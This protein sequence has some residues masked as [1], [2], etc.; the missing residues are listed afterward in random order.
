MPISFGSSGNSVANVSSVRQ[1]RAVAFVIADTVITKDVHTVAASGLSN[2]TSSVSS[3]R[4]RSTRALPYSAFVI[5]NAPRGIVA[6]SFQTLPSVGVVYTTREPHVVTATAYSTQAANVQTSNPPRAFAS[7]V[8]DIVITRAKHS[9]VAIAT[10]PVENFALL[11]N[12]YPLMY[13][14]LGSPS[15][16]VSDGFAGFDSQTARFIHALMD[17]FQVSDEMGSLAKVLQSLSDGMS[18]QDVARLIIQL[19]LIDHF[20]ASDVV[21]ATAK[22]TVMLADGWQPD[23]SATPLATIL[24]ALSDG[25]FASVVLNTGADTYTAWVMNA[26]TRAVSSY[27]NFPFNSFAMFGGQWLAAGPGGVYVMGGDTDSGSPVLPRLRTGLVNFGNEDKLFRVD[28]AYIGG[29]IQGDV[30]LKVI[31]TTL[32]GRSAEYI[33]RLRPDQRDEL[34]RHGTDIGRGFRSVYWT[35]ELLTDAQGAQFQITDLTPLPLQL[36]GRA[37]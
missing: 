13:S 27:S 21:T 34:R 22:V 16:Y 19:G 5:T 33:Y 14:V 3:T 4:G 18:L 11:V 8:N 9:A 28:R 17:L 30:L 31:A 2:V 25:F 15:Q 12:Q 10:Q 37:F 1:K 7:A 29:T 32:E 35:F 6:A 20:L 36:T 24:A 23:D 26:N